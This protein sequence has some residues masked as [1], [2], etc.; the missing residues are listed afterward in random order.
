MHDG[1][2]VKVKREKNSACTF[3]RKASERGRVWQYGVDMERVEEERR[4][5]A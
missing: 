5:V 4:R 3:T 2:S 1:I